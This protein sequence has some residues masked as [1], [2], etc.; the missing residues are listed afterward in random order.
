MWAEEDIP[1]E[2]VLCELIAIYKKGDSEQMANYRMIGLLTH[3]YKM[4]TTLLTKRLLEDVQGFLP[5]SQSGFRKLRSTRDNILLLAKVMDSVLAEGS[6]CVI[7]FID[8]V[9]AFDSVSHKFLEKSLFEAGA[10]HKCR[11]VFRA[12]YSK[13]SARIRVR[14]ADGENVFSEPF[15]VRRGVIQGDIVSPL[16]FIIALEALMRRHG[17]KGHTGAFGVLIDRLEYADDAALI[18]ADADAATARVTTLAAG[19]EEDA[20]M[21][22][23]VPKSKALFCRPP[24]DTGEISPSDYEELVLDHVCGA[25]GRGFDTRKGLRIHEALK[26]ERARAEFFQ[27][28]YF[29][30][31]ILDVRGSPEHRFFFVKWKGWGA[32]DGSWKHSWDLRQAEEA[33]KD[34]WKSS[35]LDPG[36]T[37]PEQPGLNRCPCCNKEFKRPQDVKAHATRGC[38]WAEAS[39]VGT[40]AE[41]AVKKAK[42]V[43]AQEAAGVVMLQDQ[44]LENVFNF[45]YRG[46]L[47]QADG[48]RTPALEQRMA[49]ARSRFGELHEVWRSPKISTDAK[50]RIYACAVVSVLTY[51]NEIWLFSEKIKAKLR[52]WNARCLA[53]ITGREHREETVD[54]T[55]DIL[56]RL[57]ARRLRWAG[58]ILRSEESNLLRR[59]LLAEAQQELEAGHATA[60]GLLMDAPTFRS[61][62]E[63]L[64]FAEDREGWRFLVS[65]LLPEGSKRKRVPKAA[66][67]AAMQ[68]GG[69]RM[70]AIK[71]VSYAFWLG[72]GYHWEDGMWVLN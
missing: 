8:F 24:V 5:E 18:D 44:R 61:V 2:V 35:G 43:K 56:E 6:T 68:G 9:A 50:I 49:I 13:A 29:V 38:P 34:F 60:G 72:G 33:I 17:G 69:K 46:F 41:K 65:G 1:E 3:L 11:A 15:P 4:L 52:G 55:F 51:G 66:A 59:V 45:G 21:K 37:I 10:S 54:P 40:R 12:I 47:F 31:R 58:H 25:C 63:L 19:A 22:I 57:R 14:Q 39:R 16:C 70:K 42:Q 30:E 32:E 20:D 64:G 67:A 23:S 7:T 71:G 48:D 26:C 36:C 53:L 27:E 28:A 62:E